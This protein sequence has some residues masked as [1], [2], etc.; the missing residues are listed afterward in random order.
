VESTLSSVFLGPDH[1]NILKTRH[2]IAHWTGE[3]GQPEAVIKQGLLS[4]QKRILEPDHPDILETWNRIAKL[5]EN[6]E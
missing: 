3:S 2:S 1:P 5:K 4:E 6:P